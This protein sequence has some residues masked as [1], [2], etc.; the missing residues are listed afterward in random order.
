MTGATDLGA[1]TGV[2]GGVWTLDLTTLSVGAHTALT[3][4]YSGDLN[5][6][7]STSPAASQTVNQV[8]T[9]T[10]LTSAAS[11]VTYGH[12]VTLTAT[13]TPSSATGQVTF[14]DGA[15]VLGSA[16]AASGQATFTTKLLASGVRSLQAR[17]VGDAND[18]LSTS[19]VLS[20]TVSAVAGQGFRAV[21]SFGTIDQNTYG[22]A[23]GDFN[24]DGIGDLA[25]ANTDGTIDIFL[26][27]ANG[28]FGT[29]T[30]Y[31][32]GTGLFVIAA[33]DF[34][35]DGFT[36][37]VTADTGSN[38]IEVLLNDG[39]GA[40]PSALA[41]AVGLTP[42]TLA[43]GDFNN[44]GFAD[45]VVGNS[46]ENTVTVLLGDGNGNFAPST[47]SPFVVGNNPVS[48][49]IGD[50]NGDG[51]ADLAVANS[52]DDTVSILL[53][54]GT[55]GFTATAGSPY[56]VGAYPSA[57]AIGYFNGDAFA[58]LAV[59]NEI[60]GTLS[61]LVGD[62]TGAFAAVTGNPF[63][64]SVNPLA[65]ATGDF[66]GD[67]SADLAIAGENSINVLLGNGDGTFQTFASYG[68]DDNSAILVGDF[69]GDG[70]ADIAATVFSGSTM[71]DV[72]LGA[73]STTTTLVSS[74]NPSPVGGSVTFTATM[75]PLSATG[76]VTFVD[77]S[78]VLGSGA[79]T[80]SSG[81]ASVAVT[82][83][84]LG[85]HSVTAVYSGDTTDAASTSSVLTQTVEVATT[86]TLTSSLN[87][88]VV[89]QSV[90]LTATLSDPTGTGTVTFFNGSTSLGTGTLSSGVA[91]LVLTSLAPGANSLTAVYGGD[92]TF[93]GS[94][95]TALIQTV[96]E[97][98]TTTTLISSVNPSTVGQSVTLRATLSPLSAT[99]IITFYD[100]STSLGAVPASSGIAM[101]SVTTLTAGSHA[102]SAVY[103]G[104]GSDS[105]STS[106][107][108]TQ[109]VNQ[110]TTTTLTSSASPVVYGHTVT[111]TATVTPSTATGKVTF[112]DGTTVLGTTT[113]TSGQ[114]VFT[115][116]LL[117]SGVR[118][119]RA[120]YVGDTNDTFSMSTALAQTVNAADGGALA[121]AVQYGT[122]S[123]PSGVATGDFNGDGIADTAV[124]NLF[125]GTV[126]VSFGVGDGTFGT[127]ATYPAGVNLVSIA[128]GAFNG[129][130]FA[131]LVV[132]DQNLS[133]VAILLNNGSG[134][135]SG[136]TT[137]NVGLSPS[138]VAVGDFNSDGFA[139][140]AVTN[141]DDDTVT[142]LLGDGAGGFTAANGSPYVVGVQPSSVAVGYL[143]NDASADLVV[144][145]LVDDTVSVLLGAGDGTFP[146]GTPPTYLVGSNP[147][148]VAVGYLA[149]SGLAYL[150]VTNEFDN[151]LSVL[152][153]D[154]TGAF[155]SAPNSPFSTAAAPLS[156]TLAD[157]N[158]DGTTDVVT[159]G[160]NGISVLMGNGN[161]SFQTHTDY[162]TD[163]IQD[164]AV[165][166]FNGDG[167]ADV[168]ATNLNSGNTLNI[169]LGLP[170][171]TTTL[172]SSSNPSTF[173]GSVTLTATLAPLSATGSVTFMDGSTVLGSGA[174]TLSSGIATLALTSLS[175]GSHAVT[176]VYS[177]DGNNAGSTSAV[178]TQVVNQITTTTT[179]TS[180][181]NPS[182][183]GASV[184]LTATLSDTAAT[185]SV[186]FYNG[187][188]QPGHRHGHQRHSG[189]KFFVSGARFEFFDCGLW[190]GRELQHQHFNGVV[191]GGGER[192]CNHS[193][194]FD[195]PISRESKRYAN[196]HAIF[197]LSER[198]GDV[199]RRR[200][201]LGRYRGEFG[202]CDGFRLISDGG[203]AF[204]N[205]SIRRGQQQRG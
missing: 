175:S 3:A 133:R 93:A 49:A 155:S 114:A 88:S 43:V 127:A 174:V 27:A 176:A 75:A 46:G 181:L 116:T 124:A 26:G 91:T 73:A 161:G 16:A 108:L 15:T 69:N 84:S 38:Q 85:T 129:D 63:S 194:F 32:V 48:V 42:T 145:N 168:A 138:W 76:T 180:S 154:G 202:R 64:L 172:T 149:G 200:H 104:D 36:D 163:G 192:N 131:D 74:L 195:E 139:D 80:L 92:L 120:Y 137:H 61:I 143:N 126:S 186:I 185:G 24:G 146:A 37:L 110:P 188:D 83:L 136:P 166:D 117:A 178:L 199:L 171:T 5:F 34:N 40:F 81:I 113:I 150:A 14:Y 23:M 59:A 68:T 130:G 187:S 151:T 2:S 98:G 82:T 193:H 153:G 134:V 177:G 9:T 169:L 66:N 57:I 71:V 189:S 103:G 78:T 70:I 29:P 95:S 141:E 100:G 60:D 19:T 182:T 101:V 190:R 52:S 22:I 203:R 21:A 72:L 197:P 55:G 132:V 94:T 158:G 6:Q 119:L 51:L 45:L 18:A 111:L 11:P 162:S 152:N 97:P 125:D 204:F 179:L 122:G 50:F 58:D 31:T 10:A 107:I 96:N 112:Y 99:G 123:G 156:V 53:G 87:P 25:V 121:T 62:G 167:I 148:A 165:G 135:F 159:G 102:L 41:V 147:T 35:R 67:G 170:A 128:T 144:T 183:L 106:S 105:G 7:P 20:Q 77:G 140:L 47:G 173:G 118:S 86:T 205:R 157:F 1:G 196:G 184:T 4:V 89:G 142:V 39:T 191:S 13:L 30:S 65:M 44:D 109:T 28:A 56:A 115:T 79:V 160:L 198:D 17:Y 164:I 12:T 201:E 54:D 33:G 90:T 8:P